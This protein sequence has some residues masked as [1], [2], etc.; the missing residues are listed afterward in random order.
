MASSAESPVYVAL[1]SDIRASRELEDRAGVQ[2]RLREALG[3]VDEQL[4]EDLAA[5]FAITT[6]DE[7][8]GLLATPEP[9]VSTMGRLAEALPELTLA[10]GLGIGRLETQLRQE[11]VGMDGPCFHEA[12]AALA[13]AKRADRWACLRGLDEADERFLDA[14]LGLLGAARADWTPTQSRYARARRDAD[15]L[16]QVADAFDRAKSSVSESLSAAHASQVHEAERALGR[17]ID[18]RV[19]ETRLAGGGEG[20]R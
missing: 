2:S 11:A 13:D 6:G 5:R 19:G 7:F 15:T 14:M 12:R 8:Q 4:G 10:F 17:E 16:Q 18:R 1:I 3:E 9:V 20:Q